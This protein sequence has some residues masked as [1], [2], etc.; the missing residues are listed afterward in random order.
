MCEN[1]NS[2]ESMGYKQE[3]KRTLKVKDLVIFGIVS[4]SPQACMILFGSMTQISQGHSVLAYLIG[5]IA[6]LFTAFS[7]GKMVQAFPVAGSTYSFT[8]KAINSKLGFISGWLM[9]LDYVFIP[10]VLIV[11]SGNFSHALI[12]EIPFWAWII[13]Y[14]VI[15]TVINLRGLEVA[16]KANFIIT[17]IMILGIL[18]FIIAAAK[19]ILGENI[20]STALVE[21]IYNSKNFSFNPVVSASALAV[22]SYFGFDAISTMTEEAAVSPKKVG[23]SIVIACIIE[24]IIYVSVAYF[25]TLVTPDYASIKD[26]DIAFF[27]IALTIGGTAFQTFLTLIIMVTG[28]A[29][30][31]AGQIAASRLLFGMGRDK[32]IPSKVFAH[33]SPKY[34]TPTYSIL[35]MSFITVI[36]ALTLSFTIINEIVT[37]GG[38][39]G[40]ICVNI[41]VVVQC[42]IKNKD[43]KILGNFIFPIMGATIC[44]YIWISLSSVAKIV[45]FTWMAI[46]IVYLTVRILASK[47]F[48]VLLDNVEVEA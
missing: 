35:I 15:V 7:Y 48:K 5:F 4:M 46:G 9:L 10:L 8:K 36:C 3:L 31:L 43:R 27:E 38:L 44:F 29:T 41:A 37:F 2:I 42:F 26:T 22:V 19:Y 23:D 40:F 28:V 20:P 13:I 33:L 25:A 18:S 16:A 1:K 24:T 11:V 21:A 6:M 30:A 32:L 14:T 39:F 17:G 12:P 45:G 47:D 34:K